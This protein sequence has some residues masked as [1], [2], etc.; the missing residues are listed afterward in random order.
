MRTLRPAGGDSASPTREPKPRLLIVDDDEQFCQM[1]RLE[2]DPGHHLDEA[3]SAA[4]GWQRVLQINPDVVLLDVGMET[5]DAGLGLLRKIRT[6][7]TPPAVVMITEHDDVSTIVSSMQGGAVEY[8]TKPPRRKTLRQAV[9]RG[10]ENRRLRMELA[11]RS[12]RLPDL[13]R[14]PIIAR[15][16]RMQGVLKRVEKAAR[17]DVPVILTGETGTG[18]D[19]MAYQ[20]HAQSRRKTAEFVAFSCNRQNESLALSELFG[21]EQGSFT[22]A[23]Q[24]RQGALEKANA[25][26]LFLNELGE[27]PPRLQEMLLSANPD[28]PHGYERVGGTRFESDFRLV[29]ATSRNV[30]RMRQQGLLRDDLYN[31]VAGFWIHIPPL[32]SRPDDI[33]P[34]AQSFLETACVKAELDPKTFAPAAAEALLQHEWPGN[35][36]EL[37]NVVEAA[38]TE[39]VTGT[40]IEPWHL[41]GLYPP[42][43]EPVLPYEEMKQR[44]VRSL[45]RR[46]LHELLAEARGN[47]Q[48]AGRISGVAIGTLYRWAKEYGIDPDAYRDGAGE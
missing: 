41:T 29:A 10:I 39:C 9:E 43:G 4:E 20:I 11:L 24:R 19:L 30:T 47:V 42:A 21:Y 28:S 45:Q 3:H 27:C 2:V 14:Q 34:L 38:V 25:G 15:D 35:V 32:R 33:L 23:V 48:E 18:K 1:M 46:Y 37:G 22:G 6:L 7:P 31:R 12:E 44:T 26:T 40:T 17:T 13:A 8:V 16:Q 5:K 36:R